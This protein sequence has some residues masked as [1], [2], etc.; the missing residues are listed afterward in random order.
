MTAQGTKEFLRAFFGLLVLIFLTASGPAR[1][2]NPSDLN[3]KQANY[4]FQKQNHQ[5]TGTFNGAEKWNGTLCDGSYDYA[6]TLGADLETVDFELNDN[7]TIAIY[8]NLKDLYSAAQGYYRSERSL[9]VPLKGWSGVGLDR[10]EI[11]VEAAFQ[12]EGENLNDIK[13]R[14]VA[15]KLGRL[16]L[17]NAVP[18][19]FEQFV[20][21]MLNK[22][23]VKIWTSKL[24]EWI[25]LQISDM[26]KKKIPAA[27]EIMLQGGD[28]R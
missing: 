16:H 23:L 20:T 1:G 21:G 24:G 13:V 9:C 3:W 10:A 14:V 2:V 28:R 6:V 25:S 27:P 11:F 22:A 17:G 7:G 26:I 15:T 5:L 18:A 4:D 12:G 19:W 8:A